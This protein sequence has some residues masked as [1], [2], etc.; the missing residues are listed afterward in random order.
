VLPRHSDAHQ[1]TPFRTVHEQTAQVLSHRCGS[2]NITSR[3]MPLHDTC[4][5]L[6]VRVLVTL[7]NPGY[8]MMP[9]GPIVMTRREQWVLHTVPSACHLFLIACVPHALEMPH[10]FRILEWS[11]HEPTVADEESAVAMVGGGD[12]VDGD[13]NAHAAESVLSDASPRRNSH[14][15]F[16]SQSPFSNHCIS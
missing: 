14:A 13:I 8:H 11:T 15:T 7:S 9:S 1:F 12:P 4:I 3:P 5:F 16:S 10:D 2:M 6:W